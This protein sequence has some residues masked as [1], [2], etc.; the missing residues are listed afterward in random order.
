MT[1]YL[2]G[3]DAGNTM[4]KVVLF[5]LQ[6]RELQSTRRRNPILFPA[7]GQ[8]ER[9][10][11]AMWDDLCAAVRE[12]LEQ[13]AVSPD[14]IAAVSVS[15][16][17]AGLYLVDAQGRAVRPGI[18]STDYRV[19]D[20]LAAWDS[21]GLSQRN[22]LRVQQRLWSG[23]SAPLLAWLQAHEPE[24]LAASHSILFCKDYL[25]AQLC[26]DISTDPTD[27]G[28]SGLL[29]VAAA[30]YPGDFYAE[31]GLSAWQAKLPPVG[32]ST[33]IVGAV[34]AAA[35][36]ATGL[37]VGTPVVR[38]LVDVC[39]AA[40]AAGVRNPSQLSVIAGTFSISS[41]LHTTPRLDSL[42]LLQMAY[43]VGGYYLASEGSATS[44]SNFEWYCKSILGP[45]SA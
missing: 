23:Q 40:L 12:L 17:G 42:P 6:G 7:P 4:T 29:D 35:A 30:S 14:R 18:M 10:P 19:S 1:Q 36:Q 9:D 27:A 20:V 45:E 41:T 21:A 3:L 25:R 8:T 15:G 28:I 24:S 32:A 33:E 22:G 43:P 11:Q 37:R 34:S 5:D 16:Y 38:G 44:A 39:A 13:S 31:L 2:L 26:G